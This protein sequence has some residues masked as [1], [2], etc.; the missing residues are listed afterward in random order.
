MHD[1]WFAIA[2][3]NR[4][5]SFA[6]LEA[7]LP[8]LTPDFQ[9]LTSV[10][11]S[12]FEIKGRFPS[13]ESLHRLGGI[14]KAGVILERCSYAELQAK[15]ISH[16]LRHEADRYDFGLSTYSST[17]NRRTLERLA[18]STKQIVK[19]SSGR[20]VR[21]VF[22][23]EGTELAT[24]VIAKQLLG[25]GG[26]EFVI[27]SSGKD[28]LLA[29]TRWVHPFEEWGAREFGKPDVDSRRGLLPQK[30]ARIMLNLSGLNLDENIVVMDPFCGSGVILMEARELGCEFWGSD[31]DE[32]AVLASKHNLG[33][34][35][36]SAKVWKADACDVVLP[37]V[38]QN[39]QL[40][41]VTEPYLGPLWHGE[42]A[43]LE[44]E[45]VVQELVELYLEALV[46]WRG[47]I[48]KGTRVVM[49]FPVILGVPTF[50][51]IVDRLPQFK[52]TLLSKP[53]LYERDSTKVA[54]EIVSLEAN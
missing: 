7:Q 22:P 37:Q 41:I 14:V 53:I 17:W 1:H 38:G 42:V 39:Q 15:L 3:K 31:I 33:I 40:V 44:K 2:G 18:I 28:Y 45:R 50:H 51:E 6:E 47:A 48:Q 23:Q 27:L 16:I 11:D 46:H 19:K 54:R 4:E 10:A 26:R 52:Y 25:K 20:A 9:T 34:P 32:R 36:S 12:Y 29:E 5:L 35:E 43:R 13:V 24:P 49:I 8:Q 30:L 21:V